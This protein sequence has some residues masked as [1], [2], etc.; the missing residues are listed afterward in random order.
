MS[1]N[2]Y[3]RKHRNDGVPSQI[4][5]DCGLNV[6]ALQLLIE[7]YTSHPKPIP[8]NFPY[9]GVRIC[10]SLTDNDPLYDLYEELLPLL[11]KDIDELYETDLHN[12]FLT[13]QDRI[14]NTK[15]RLTEVK[16]D[17]RRRS[18]GNDKNTVC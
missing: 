13:I 6:F 15:E 8:V 3:T 17:E 5:L 11:D 9:R 1:E 10:L 7:S 14:R 18:C 12:F 4:I 2:E 16:K